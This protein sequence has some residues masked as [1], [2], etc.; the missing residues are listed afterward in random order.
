MA[1][2]IQIHVKG[3]NDFGK[4][5]ASI[6][7]SLGAI[8]R[9]ATKATANLAL[10]FST[11]AE[12]ARKADDAT[13][14]L[15][16]QLGKLG[17]A[18]KKVKPA[19]EGVEGVAATARKAA[20]AVQALGDE[21]SA[22]GKDSDRLTAALEKVKA[23]HLEMIKQLD[24]TGDRDLLPNIKSDQAVISQLTKLKK[25]IANTGREA[26]ESLGRQMVD[27]IAGAA[28]SPYVVAAGAAIG[29]VM[30]PAVGAAISAGLLGAAGAG[31]LAA[32]IAGAAQSPEVKQ[33]AGVFSATLSEELISIGSAFKKPVV[34]ALDELRGEIGQLDLSGMFAPLAKA[35]DPLAKGLIG[36]V[37]EAGPGLRQM[38]AASAPFIESVAGDLPQLGE[39]IGDFSDSIA[40][41]GPGAAKFFGDLVD[42]TADVVDGLGE[43]IEVLSKLYSGLS[44]L[45]EMSGGRLADTLL[46]PLGQAISPLMDAWDMLTTGFV[47]SDEHFRSLGDSTAIASA[48]L[49]VAAES[50]KALADAEKEAADATKD[51]QDS[52]ASA[53]EAHLAFEEGIDNLAES[54]R[55]HGRSLDDS[56]AKGRDNIGMFQDLVG[57]AVAAGEA[58]YAAAVAQGDLA[59]ASYRAAAAQNA[60]IAAILDQAAAMGYD[61]EQVQALIN[62]ILGLPTGTKTMNYVINEWHYVRYQGQ[63]A[64]EQA[65][66]GSGY[67]H[68][69]EGGW[70]KP[71]PVLV[72]E[73][74]PEL[75]WETK[76]R[77][78]STAQETKQMMGGGGGGGSVASGGGG[79]G[80]GSTLVIGSDGSQLG[81][82]LLNILA[83]AIKK[84][85]GSPDLLNIKV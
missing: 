8:N 4:T 9:Q 81:D 41:A 65:L 28:R 15:T 63:D 29:V 20:P 19:A 56:T 59:G 11:A 16:E 10:A 6:Q 50:A 22:A 32:G 70:T 49:S 35:V 30:A 13:E 62:R 64:R 21:L 45:N 25:T 42:G 3:D 82:L 73:E 58:E 48:G 47:D 55:E 66:Y 31:G 74:G 72:G 60:V 7:R 17:A 34:T 38:F 71:G 51:L 14:G 27:G 84:R 68:N 23:R 54:T 18:G 76:P 53:F 69:A 61:R 79:G 33:A 40:S 80:G 77:W 12:T 2:D 44:D 78:V 85:G 67:T 83:I 37:R 5:A 43:T 39:A 36:M 57:A 24:R 1:N 52:F 75:I 26:G 46:G